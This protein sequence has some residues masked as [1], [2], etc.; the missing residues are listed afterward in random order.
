MGSQELE[1]KHGSLGLFVLSPFVPFLLD[2]IESICGGA[3][4]GR[5]L[6]FIY[7]LTRIGLRLIRSH[8]SPDDP[9]SRL[10]FL[11]CSLVDRFVG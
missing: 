4:H 9:S 5:L 2:R 7:K 6:P 3:F 8:S 1:N 11:S 10:V